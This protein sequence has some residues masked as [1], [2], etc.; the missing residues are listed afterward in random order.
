MSLDMLQATPVQLRSLILDYLAYNGYTATARAFICDSAIRHI[1]VDGD[2]VMQDHGMGSSS[3]ESLESSLKQA[4]LRKQIRLELLCGRT[5][6]AT[7]LLN[8][9]FPDV[10][11]L[12]TPLRFEDTLIPS[13]GMD[14]LAPNSVYPPHLVLNL[15]IQAFVEACRTIPLIHPSDSSHASSSYSSSKVADTVDQQTALLN[16]AQK[17]YALAKMLPS[18]QDIAR[19]MKELE[20]VLG[21][22]AYRVPEESPMSEYLS[23]GRREAVADQIDYAILYHS[24][25]P[26][27]SHLELYTRYTTTIWDIL[28]RLEVKPHPSIPPTGAKASVPTKG[29]QEVQDICPPFDLHS[30]VNAT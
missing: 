23:Q 22:L 15:K 7:T 30:F 19:Y 28:H 4:E 21:L 17:L 10:L 26:V 29:R 1:G 20:S 8:K 2:E 27:I 25:R 12:A 11:S 14:Y 6:E 18:E 24:K 13:S 5:D 3:S 9:Y 16:S